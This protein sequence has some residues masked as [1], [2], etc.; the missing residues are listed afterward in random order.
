MG[1]D[2]SLTLLK[3]E[4]RLF[5]VWRKMLIA[6]DRKQTTDYKICVLK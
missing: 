6:S 3:F 4:L 5:T 2:K 1:L